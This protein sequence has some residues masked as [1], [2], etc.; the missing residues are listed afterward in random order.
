MY[1]GEAGSVVA[2]FSVATSERWTDKQGKTVEKT[3]W[4]R[5]VCFGKLAELCEKY[6]KKGRQVYVEGR[7][8]TQEWMDKKTNEKRQ[9]VEVV[10]HNV[11]FLGGA[12]KTGGA[13][14]EDADAEL[15]AT[16]MG[17]TGG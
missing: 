7:L 16:D 1:R 15:P 6:L 3:E 8:E 13:V 9:T 12:R 10:A 14:E 17:Y 5:V 2:N 4:H 11:L